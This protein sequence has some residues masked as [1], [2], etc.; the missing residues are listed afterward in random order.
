VTKRDAIIL[1]RG[2]YNEIGGMGCLTEDE[3]VDCMVGPFFDGSAK[4]WHEKIVATFDK[5]KIVNIG[6][7]ND[8]NFNEDNFTPEELRVI[9]LISMI[10]PI[11]SL[12]YGEGGARGELLLKSFP[13]MGELYWYI[14]AIRDSIKEWKPNGRSPFGEDL[15]GGYV[16]PSHCYDLGLGAKDPYV[17]SGDTWAYPSLSVYFDEQFNVILRPCNSGSTTDW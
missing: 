14:D 15:M 5:G 9:M 13:H 2:W 11:L 1:V 8:P 3:F 10:E 16:L 12:A 6:N 17:L 7:P 4:Q